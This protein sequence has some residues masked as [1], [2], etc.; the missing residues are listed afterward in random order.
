MRVLHVITKG[1]L[2]GAQRYL[3]ELATRQGRAG[4]HVELASGTR[5]W[6]TDQPAFTAVHDVPALVR[7]I[8]PRRDAAVV[9]DLWRLI[10]RGRFEVVHTHSSKAGVVGRLAAALA[11]VRVVAHTSHGT[12]LAERISRR[13]RAVYFIGEQAGAIL[14][15]RLFAVS[16]AERDLLRRTLVTRPGAIRVMT[17]VPEHVRAIAPAWRLDEDTRWD[18]VAVGNLYR[19]KAYDVLLRSLALLAPVHPRLRATIHGE[20]PERAALAAQAAELGLAERVTFPGSLADVP[21][22]FARAGIFVLPSRKEGLPLVLLEAMATGVPVAATAVGA[23][24]RTLGPAV[25]VARPD[26]HR[27]FARLLDR[28]LASDPERVRVGDAGRV[29]LEAVLASDDPAAASAMYV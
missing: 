21:T 14:S 22:A 12:P 28:L 24:G 7:E 29:A 18:L 4:S 13:R 27:D 1:E 9:R 23:V 10:R 6:L 11:R 16:T 25:P 19:N 15:H 5:G 26:D 20:G 17:I 2:G 8:E 3:A